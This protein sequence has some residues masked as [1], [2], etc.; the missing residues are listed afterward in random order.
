MYTIYIYSF[1]SW[2]GLH[3]LLVNDRYTGNHSPEV[4]G[5]ELK[6]L[7]V[8]LL[9]P[10]DQ[11][12]YTDNSIYPQ[13]N[14]T[15]WL[16]STIGL[17]WFWSTRPALKEC[18]DTIRI[19]D[20]NKIIILANHVFVGPIFTKKCILKFWSMH[21]LQYICWNHA[22][23]RPC[24]FHS[25]QAPKN[26]RKVCIQHLFLQNKLNKHPQV[27]SSRL[28]GFKHNRHLLFVTFVTSRSCRCNLLK[29][30]MGKW[31]VKSM[32]DYCDKC[33]KQPYHMYTRLDSE[34]RICLLWPLNCNHCPSQHGHL[35]VMVIPRQPEAW[36]KHYK[37]GKTIWP[38]LLTFT[39]FLSRKF[40]AC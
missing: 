28:N 20:R 13:I 2:V 39:I 10:T 9:P 34:H 21:A 38:V 32:A 15:S 7:Q 8:Q 18:T 26:P 25:S 1:P 30:H 24:P 17:N 40:L 3:K 23:F 36:N 14:G 16:K 5:E 19:W 4:H 31:V 11:D 12:W 33:V 6:Q 35:Q 27:G 22:G 37:R 29:S